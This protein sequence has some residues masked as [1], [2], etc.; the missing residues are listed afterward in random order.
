[1]LMSEFTEEKQVTEQEVT[2]NAAEETVVEEVVEE[3]EETAVVEAVVE[4]AEETAEDAAQVMEQYSDMPNPVPG[5]LIDGKVVQVNADE[6]LVDIGYKS[7]GRITRNELG[8]VGDQTP[9]DVTAVG[10][11][12]TVLVLKVDDAEGNVLLSKRRADA[13]QA[14]EEL[15]QIQAENRTITANVIQVVKGGLLVNVGVRGFIPASHVSRNFVDDLEK[16]VGQPLELKIVELDREKNNVV[17]SHKAV[18]D[19]QYEASK[20]ET[21]A[22]IEEGTDVKGVVRRIT[23]FGAFVDIG[24]GV[25]GLLHVSEMAYSRIN[26]PSDVV[27]END[28]ITVRVLGVDQE[29]ERISLGL[30]QT[31]AD[32]WTTI[33]ERYSVD[34]KVEGVVTRTVDFGAFVKIEDGVEGLV[35]ISQLSHN[36]VAKTEDVVKSGDKVNVKVISLDPA[37][38]RIGLS[39]RELEPKP[40]APAA[41]A[42]KTKKDPAY[43]KAEEMNNNQ[44]LTTTI[45]D[46]FGDLFK[47]N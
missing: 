32:P 46:M 36:H 2:E 35:H 11:D 33:E 13:K 41:P 8:L 30:K 34:D 42:R 16:Y 3:A 18:L 20:A 27:A 39:I 10:D 28:E 21:Y 25:E 4:E 22:N 47:D 31:L 24:N 14:W 43:L 7:E 5:N 23:D 44:E 40:A 1:M 37:G 6:V 38:R 17:F 15:E 9:A 26:H 45:G 29:R 19:E 12:V